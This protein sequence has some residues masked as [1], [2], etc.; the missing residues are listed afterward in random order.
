MLSFWQYHVGFHSFLFFIFNVFLE[1]FHQKF[2][3]LIWNIY[4]YRPEDSP[5]SL[6][7]PPK[8]SHVGELSSPAKRFS[9]TKPPES[10]DFFAQKHCSKETSSISSPKLT[11]ITNVEDVEI[12]EVPSISCTERVSAPSN[13]PSRP[14]TIPK[15]LYTNVSDDNSQNDDRTPTPT[16]HERTRNSRTPS[17]SSASSIS[18]RMIGTNTLESVKRSSETTSRAAKILAE[19]KERLLILSRGASPRNLTTNANNSSPLS[20]TRRNNDV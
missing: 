16:K 4:V 5:K 9:K 1:S 13:S 20:A 12:A 3:Y 11:S 8:P 10:N 18:G 7:E 15:A 17:S 14:P 19:S 6:T 2:K